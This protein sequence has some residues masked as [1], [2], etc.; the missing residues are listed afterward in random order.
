MFP[1]ELYKYVTEVLHKDII[2]VLNKV[3]LAPS[4]LVVAWR[5]YFKETFPKLHIVLFTTLPGYNLRGNQNEKS[6]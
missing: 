4:S 1:P 6:G 2:I 5:H 3:D